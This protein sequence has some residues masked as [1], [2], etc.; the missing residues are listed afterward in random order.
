MKRL[1]IAL[2]ALFAI[3]LSILGIVR[4]AYPHQ[5]ERSLRQ[6]PKTE[7]VNRLENRQV[8]PQTGLDFQLRNIERVTYIGGF[9]NPIWSPADANTLAFVSE[10]NPGTFV[11]SRPARQLTKLTD[12]V[13]GFKFFFTQDGAR[14]IYRAH[15][16]E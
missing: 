1:P 5:Q 13:A 7:P 8:E 2:I 9:T 6:E 3:T 15:A 12:E 14:I 4:V 16:E 11:F 10:E